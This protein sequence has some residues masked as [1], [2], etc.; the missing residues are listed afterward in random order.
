VRLAPLLSV[1]AAVVAVVLTAAAPSALAAPQAAPQ[2]AA[3]AVTQLRGDLDVHD[4]AFL[5]G[6]AGQK[7]YVFASGKPDKGGGTIDIRSSA[8]NGRTWAYDG[9]VWDAMPAWLHQTV[10]GANNMWAPAIHQHAGTY[11]LYY[12]VSTTGHNDSVIG[13]ATNT[14]LDRTNPAYKWVDQGKVV[15]S[16]PASDFNAID[17]E[18]TEDDAGTPWL[19]FGSYWTGIQMVQLEWPSGK[20]SA[21]RT[22]LYLADRKVNPNAI[23]APSIVHRGGWFYLFT[24]WDRC[25]L[26]VDS[27]YRIVVGRSKTVTGPYVDHDGRALTD[28]GGT[29]VLSSKGDRVGPGGESISGDVIA[30]H[31]YDGAA[32]GSPTLGLRQLAW[33]ADGW[34][35]L[36]AGDQIKPGTPTSNADVS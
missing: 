25:C 24:S 17:P 15:R 8:D 20:R 26:G 29:T 13:L 19:V 10:P 1:T 35:Q 28:G 21:D 31:Y 36:R 9:T 18:V 14:T 2:T 30:Y 11:Y 23:E 6:G 22:R 5:K 12:A 32:D 33:T 34:P 27:T 16:L 4:P 7:W 3:K